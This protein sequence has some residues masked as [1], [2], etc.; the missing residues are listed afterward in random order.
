M[1]ADDRESHQFPVVDLTADLE[2]A[3][4]ATE[5]MPRVRDTRLE[6]LAEGLGDGSDEEESEPRDAPEP[7]VVW[8]DSGDWTYCGSP[9][10]HP[11]EDVDTEHWRSWGPRD[12]EVWRGIC[13]PCV[14]KLEER[15]VALELVSGPAEELEVVD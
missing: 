15:G 10:A 4:E 11:D 5:D 3:G 2:P 1:E 14:T 7:V 6:G 13:A 8:T 9:R 12:Q